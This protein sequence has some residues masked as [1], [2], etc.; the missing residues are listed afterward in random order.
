VTGT[1]KASTLI[2]T[3]MTLRVDGS[4]GTVEIIG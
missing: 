1:G 3:G 4:N 2:T